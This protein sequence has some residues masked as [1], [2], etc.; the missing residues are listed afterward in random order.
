MATRVGIAQH[1]EIH[2]QHGARKRLDRSCP[3]A[4]ATVVLPTPPLPTMVTKREALSWDRR[5][6]E[7]RRRARP[8]ASSGPADWRA[9]SGQEPPRCALFGSRPRDR[10]DEA[11]SPAGDG[12]DVPCAARPVA[13][14]LAEAS[15]VKPQTAFFDRGVGPD[16]GQHIPFAD[17]LVGPGQQN[18]QSIEGPRA[19]LDF[20]AI[21]REESL[22]TTRLNG[23]NEITSLA[24]LGSVNMASSS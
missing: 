10:R 4:T 23:P 16:A 22:L 18:D 11:I 20:C 9:E 14:G 2:E 6:F 21:P 24:W 7:C 5:L 3:T 15:H 8:S 12:G 19:Q 1:S 17:D 13:Q